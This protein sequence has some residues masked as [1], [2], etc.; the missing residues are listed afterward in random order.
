M[1]LQILI[2]RLL[3]SENLTDNLDDEA[4]NTLINWGIHQID[5]LAKNQDDET[6]GTRVNRLMALMR[7]VNSIAG[8]PS[9]VTSESLAR[10][11]D[12]FTQIFDKDYQIDEEERRTMAQQISQMQ[13]RDAVDYLLKWMDSKP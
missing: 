9:Q 5:P 2:D 3:E 13:S 10:L 11:T 12:R 1:D 6:A 4:A 7:A 8:N